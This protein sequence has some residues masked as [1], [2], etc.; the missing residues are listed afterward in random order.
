MSRPEA[1]DAEIRNRLVKRREQL[2]ARKIR[3]ERDALHTDAP[4]PADFSEQVVESR[5]DAVLESIDE[6]AVAE[7]AEIDAALA[8][9]EEGRYG[10]CRSCHIPIDRRRLA[11]VPQAITCVPCSQAETALRR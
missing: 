11:A 4:L 1:K 9:L 3:V 2:H 6:A 10:I 8:Q 7:I 5:N